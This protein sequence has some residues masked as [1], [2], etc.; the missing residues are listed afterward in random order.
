MKIFSVCFALMMMGFGGGATASTMESDTSQVGSYLNDAMFFHSHNPMFIKDSSSTLTLVDEPALQVADDKKSHF[1]GHIILHNR[2]SN[3]WFVNSGLVFDH[4]FFAGETHLWGWGSVSGN[5]IDGNCCET[6]SPVG[7]VPVP[8]AIW[9]F[10]SALL[11]LL[12]LI[13]R[14]RGSKL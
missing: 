9:L 2:D 7:V 8:S 5:E 14:N 12:G 4:S 3:N 10:G 13:S 1:Y 6:I 11:G